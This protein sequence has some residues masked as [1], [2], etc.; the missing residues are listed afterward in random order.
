MLERGADGGTWSPEIFAILEFLMKF[1]ELLCPQEEPHVFGQRS[2]AEE[3]MKNGN[4]GKKRVL[5]HDPL[6]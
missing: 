5:F 6:L 2:R 4:C 1:F 3:G